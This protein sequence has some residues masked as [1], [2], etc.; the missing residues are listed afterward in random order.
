MFVWWSGL[1]SI[2]HAPTSLNYQWECIKNS[3]IGCITA[4]VDLM[5]STQTEA[6]GGKT[7]CSS[8]SRCP[9]GP[10]WLSCSSGPCLQRTEANS[11]LWRQHPRILSAFPQASWLTAA[12]LCNHWWSLSSC[13]PATF[14]S[15]G[16]SSRCGKWMSLSFGL[17]QGR[18]GPISCLFWDSSKLEDV[19][20]VSGEKTRG[21]YD[22][23]KY[24][25]LHWEETTAQS[26]HAVT[27]LATESG[28][29]Q[30]G[31]KKQTNKPQTEN[32]SEGMCFFL[33][34][35]SNGGWAHEGP[36]N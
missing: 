9:Q 7:T 2:S 14:R 4:G 34:P 26:H 23:Y 16:T 6:Q 24:C 33:T 36:R 28:R 19:W 30:I 22:S 31:I 21:A 35:G 20:I 27:M 13:F 3:G 29:Q 12:I 8:C 32:Y 5:L 1:L 15:L 17:H 10:M 11:C 25:V 18:K